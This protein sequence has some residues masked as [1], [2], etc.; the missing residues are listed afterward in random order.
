MVGDVNVSWISGFVLYPL[1]INMTEEN[2]S[3]KNIEKD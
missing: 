3:Q 2:E 1:M